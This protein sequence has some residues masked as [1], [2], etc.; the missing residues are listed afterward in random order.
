[1]S[2]ILRRFLYF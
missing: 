1:V 2:Q